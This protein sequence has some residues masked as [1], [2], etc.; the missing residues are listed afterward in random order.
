MRINGMLR[1]LPA[2]L[3]LTT[4]LLTCCAPKQPPSVSGR[5]QTTAAQ[6]ECVAA[7]FKN[8]PSIVPEGKR[9][10]DVVDVPV[11]ECVRGALRQ[12]AGMVD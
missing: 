10:G 2:C 5:P 7:Y 6:K 3:L 9:A 8:I 12:W 1:R 4:M 11:P